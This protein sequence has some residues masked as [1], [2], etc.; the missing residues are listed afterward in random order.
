[1]EVCRLHGIPKSIVSDRDPLFLSAFW[2]ELFRVQGT[3]LKYS[4]AYHP[5]TDGQTEVVNRSLEA[6]LRCFT[7]DNPR[8]WFKYLHLAEF[9]H[10][11]TFH[12]AISMTPFE[13][14][15][16]RPP[17]AMPDYANGQATIADLNATLQERKEILE[18]LKSNLKRSR[19]K[20]EV[21]ANKSRKHCTF[22]QGDLVLLKLQ[23][24]RQNSVQRRVSQK[25]SKRFFGP[26][27]VLRRIGEVAYE[28]DLPPSTRIHNVFHVSQLRAYHGDDPN[29]H[30]VP[31]PH[32]MQG[33][34]LLKDTEEYDLEKN[35]SVSNKDLDVLKKNVTPST[36]EQ[37]GKCTEGSV[38]ETD[39]TILS[40]NISNFSTRP[41]MDF[42]NNLEDKVPS[43]TGGN[44]SGLD[45]TKAKRII[46][47]PFW[48]KNFIS[49]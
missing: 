22:A 18:T 6:Y 3:T 25:L 34:D 8:K 20:M 17:P 30:F 2:K 1:V 35:T 11:S 21:Q 26:F 19:K 10:N 43:E 42:N 13:A 37:D 12:S 38:L 23:P 39:S 14:L 45:P 32:E 40:Q 47:K 5:E 9:W 29:A 31:L 24:Y 49:K 16:G 33:L 15:Y 44:D 48:M 28:L 36:L 4:T 27:A 46:K 41:N 7:S